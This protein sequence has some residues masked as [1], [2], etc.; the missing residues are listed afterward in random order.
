M[1]LMTDSYIH[2]RVPAATKGRWIRAS[3]A[4]GQKLT[5]YITHAVEARVAR[6]Q[7]KPVSAIMTAAQFDALTTLLRM[8]TRGDSARAARLVLV[9]GMDKRTAAEHCGITRKALNKCLDRC[10]KGIALTCIVVGSMP[11]QAPFEAPANPA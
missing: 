7:A 9:D 11:Y 2:L 3:R 8:G 5:D 4:K 6:S 1:Q 10:Q